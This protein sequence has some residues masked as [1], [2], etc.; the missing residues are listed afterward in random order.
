M[1]IKATFL[2]DQ[3]YQKWTLACTGRLPGSKHR[4]RNGSGFSGRNKEFNSFSLA[5]LVLM[6]SLEGTFS[7]FSLCYLWVTGQPYKKWALACT[8]R[9][10][11]SKHNKRN[12]IGFSARNKGFSSSSLE[13]V[14]LL[15]SLKG[16]FSA[17]SLGYQ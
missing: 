4:Q 11:G 12:G 1:L 14:E 15:E 9:L 10:P 6:K 5:P 16:T 8:G 17:F 13:Q 2:T 7:A 3:T